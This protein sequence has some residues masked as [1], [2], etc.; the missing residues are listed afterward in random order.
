MNDHCVSSWFCSHPVGPYLWDQE[1]TT[2]PYQDR[3]SL[4]LTIAQ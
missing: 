2:D 3:P 1:W 4:H